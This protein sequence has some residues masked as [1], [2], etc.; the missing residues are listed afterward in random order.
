MACRNSSAS[1]ELSLL[2]SGAIAV[3]PSGTHRCSSLERR[4]RN[5]RATPTRN[6]LKPPRSGSN[7]PGW[8]ISHTNTSWVTSAA[9]TGSPVISRAKR[10]TH[11]WCMR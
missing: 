7:S 11:A 3:S 4:F 8:W 10:N 2:N 6:P 9:F 1:W 5:F